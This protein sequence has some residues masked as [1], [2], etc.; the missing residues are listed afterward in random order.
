MGEKKGKEFVAKVVKRFGLERAKRVKAEVKK[1]GLKPTF[2]NYGKVLD[3]P[4]IGWGGST[5]ET[6]CPFAEV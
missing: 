5:R 1:L 6:F 2:E 4:R 3:L